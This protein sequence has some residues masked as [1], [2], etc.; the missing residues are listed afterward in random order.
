MKTKLLSTKTTI[1]ATALLGGGLM[2]GAHEVSHASVDQAICDK[3]ANASA[4]QKAALQGVLGTQAYNEA[5]TYCAANAQFNATAKSFTLL[6]PIGSNSGHAFGF[7]YKNSVASGNVYS[8]QPSSK[9]GAMCANELG[10]YTVKTGPG[11][12]TKN[13]SNTDKCTN[14]STAA[15]ATIPIKVALPGT[16]SLLAFGPIMHTSPGTGNSES[17]QFF[18]TS[19][20]AASGYDGRGNV[21]LVKTNATSGTIDMG[22]VLW[23]G[24]SKGCGGGKVAVQGSTPICS[25]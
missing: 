3:L 9:G 6:F 18:S 7:F 22:K 14:T 11:I 20:L 19:K 24:G 2:I 5:V 12:E 21:N 10:T 15:C 17:A 13:P 1:L 25:N 8:L 23:C 4:T 16:D